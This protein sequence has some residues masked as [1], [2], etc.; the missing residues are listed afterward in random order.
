MIEV[1]LLKE[2]TKGMQND[3]IQ[4]EKVML[5]DFKKYLQ[6]RENAPSTIEKY[7]RDVRKFIE[8]SWREKIISKEVLLSYKT[9]LME[10]Y[11]VSSVNSMLVALNQFLQFLDMGKLRL[12]RVK[13]QRQ[14]M[15][16]M[17]KEL[18]KEEFHKLIQYARE[19]GKEQLAMIME[20]IGATGIRI[21]ELK[22][23]RVENIRNG[24]IKVWN[25]GKYRLVI[26]PRVL[27][28]KLL[29]FIKRQK[30]SSG[31]IFCTKSGREKNR[32]NIWREMKKLAIGG[33]I[34]PEKVF[35]H[36]LRHLFARVFY[37]RT[38]NLLN[39]ADIL[40]HSNLEVTRI[41]ASEGLA[42]WKRNIEQ[43]KILE[44]KTT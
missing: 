3:R 8:Y 16:S 29:N 32:S 9:W 42:E 25:K 37:K 38:K 24:L 13:M 19:Q 5:T 33:G 12:K 4:I 35:P 10:Q 27:Q 28:K 14:D 34:A 6:E 41:Y 30:I 22:F 43:L 11:S 21:S 17:G 23:F 36:N 44:I 15:Q 18:Q 31:P 39:L 7:L 26:L 40:G 1:K 2:E 20:T